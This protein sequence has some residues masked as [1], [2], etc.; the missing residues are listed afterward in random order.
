VNGPWLHWPDPGPATDAAP[1]LL[2]FPY[3]GAGRAAYRGWPEL[4]RPVRA[5]VV[6]LPG[7]DY[8]MTEPPVDGL[9]VAAERIAQEAA[10]TVTGPL[11]L[12]GHSLGAVLAY[13]TAHALT[14][15]G[16]PPVL[17]AVS[18]R[19]APDRRRVDRSLSELP[20]TEL[21]RLAARLGWLGRTP[22]DLPPDLVAALLA[23]LRSDLR[24][25]EDYAYRERQALDVRMRVFT[26][27]PADADDD[28]VDAWRRHTTGEVTVRRFT[29]GHFFV[30]EHREEIVG[31]LCA[32]VTPPVSESVSGPPESC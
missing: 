18:G 22:E 16:R 32:A 10:A 15:L 23:P 19:P 13:E 9:A 11:G 31:C 4:L 27:R 29:G 6:I 2:M 26:E 17:L 14:A 20:D 28:P 1:T 30:F 5:G 7:R 24:L 8:R 12:Y 21:R 3:A 25:S